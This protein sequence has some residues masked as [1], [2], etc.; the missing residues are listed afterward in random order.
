[1]PL[2]LL[3]V[4]VDGTL[5][6]NGKIQND[7]AG[8]LGKLVREL[9][10]LGVRTALWSNQSWTVNNGNESLQAWFSK[11][12]GVEV[13][14]HGYRVDGSPPRRN[15]N[16]A[17][18]ILKQ[19][20]VETHETVLIGGMEEDMIAGVQNQFLLLRP[21]WYKQNMDYG[22]PFNTVGELARFCFV[23]ALRQHPVFWRISDGDLDISASGPFS[24]MYQN[25]A[26]FGGDARAFA[27]HGLGH[28]DFWFYFTVS[29]L[30]F[31]GLLEGVNYICSY[32][33][34]TPESDPDEYGVASI[35]ARL[36]KCFHKNYYHDLIIRHTGAPKSQPIKA[37]NRTFLAQANTI[38]LNRQPHRNLSPVPNKAA[39]P[40]KEKTVLV[41]DDFV[42]SG[43]SSEAAR[44]FIEA[45]GG[46]A[47][48]YAWLK[49][50]N[51]S[52]ERINEK[53]KISA[54]KPANL[55]HEPVTTSYPYGQGIVDANAPM[56]IQAMFDRYIAWKWN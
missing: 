24:T 45:A 11:I 4:S 5:A 19:Y 31:S 44:A 1:M 3:L 36:G 55:N 52:Y 56:E 9:A 27:K 2:K 7:I 33:G 46:R 37:Q 50:I 48:L 51:S 13:W 15:K 23:F 47:R 49:T 41:I 28:A 35:L 6:H 40:L 26:V 12:A 42:T 53:Q 38:C 43:R 54:Y 25:Y 30:Y 20:G 10:E 18:Q 21:D 29:S 39:L 16:S 32:P 17:L 14:A 8:Q 34:H 22:F